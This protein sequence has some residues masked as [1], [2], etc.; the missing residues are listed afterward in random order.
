MAATR[1]GLTGRTVASTVA[2]NEGRTIRGG[3]AAGES[4]HMRRHA[5]YSSM[6]AGLAAAIL[7]SLPTSAAVPAAQ[8][9]V[10]HARW[11]VLGPGGG[12]TMRKP[13]ISPHDPRRVLVGCDMTGAYLTEDGGGS[14]RMFNL[15]TD[16]SS[17][18]FDSSNPDVIYAGT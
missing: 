14:W 4:P 16:V 18:A 11:E 17:F 3:S 15:G 13:T 12:G 1:P 6:T 7:V 10:K 2:P 5:R 8:D 9:S